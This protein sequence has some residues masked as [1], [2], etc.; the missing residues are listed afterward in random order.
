MHALSNPIRSLASG[1]PRARC[2]VAMRTPGE[3]DIYVIA[4]SPLADYLSPARSL[5]RLERGKGHMEWSRLEAELFG[6][7]YSC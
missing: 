5:V 2:W 1:H 4:L 6:L 7:G 3:N